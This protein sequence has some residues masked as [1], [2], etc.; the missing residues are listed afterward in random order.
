[1]NV[2]ECKPCSVSIWPE[3]ITYLIRTVRQVIRK[4]S[5]DFQNIH[6]IVRA[7]FN[8][9]CSH[10]GSFHEAHN[11]TIFRGLEFSHFAVVFI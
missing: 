11:L 4:V 1:M 10:V 8:L 9:V 3:Y 5:T 6:R 2:N 7:S